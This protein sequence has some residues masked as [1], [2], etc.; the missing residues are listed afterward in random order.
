MISIIEATICK[1]DSF[2][3]DGDILS[4]EDIIKLYNHNNKLLFD[5]NHNYKSLDNILVINNKVNEDGDW[6]I[7][8]LS[9]NDTLNNLLFNEEVKGVSL[10]SDY[11]KGVCGV[12]LKLDKDDNNY[13]YRDYDM[14]CWKPTFLSFVEYPSNKL[15]F[16]NLRIF[17]NDGELIK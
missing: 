13:D 12:P 9:I 7:N 16:N 2:D 4:K 10:S 5:V 6:I 17:N 11:D 8:L 3:S 1:A 15:P 14:E